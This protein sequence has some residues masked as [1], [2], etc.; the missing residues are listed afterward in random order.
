M[1]D[2]FGFRTP[3]GNIY[4]NGSLEGGAELSCTIVNRESGSSPAA[5]GGC[6]A[7]HEVS[8][9]LGERGPA[10]ATCGGPAGRLSVYSD[11]A[12][13]GA[14]GTF[15]R[16]VCLS[17]QTGFSCRNADGRGFFLSRRSQQVF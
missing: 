2:G 17:E 16:I 9:D 14:T 10:R 7:G 8:V 4:C 15:G 12:S 11:V 6:P 1:A 13:Y 3:T 5:I